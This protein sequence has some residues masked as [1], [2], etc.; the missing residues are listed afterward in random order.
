MRKAS[1]SRRGVRAL[2]PGTFAVQIPI[3]PSVPLVPGDYK[4]LIRTKGVAALGSTESFTFTLD[5]DPLGTGTLFFRRFGPREIPTADLRFRRTERIMVETPASLAREIS[6][7]LLGRTGLPLNVP[8]TATIRVDAD[9]TRWRRV[10]ITL[11]PLAPGEYIVET[12][13]G[14]ERTLTAFRVVP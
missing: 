13:A 1:R 5:A 12:T 14:T 2:E 10:E 6:A 4:V 9:G 11:A 8:V 3:A 7:R